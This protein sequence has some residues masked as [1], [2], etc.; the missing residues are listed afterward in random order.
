MATTYRV[1]IRESEA[2]YYVDCTKAIASI[3]KACL[4]ACRYA[5]GELLWAGNHHAKQVRVHASNGDHYSVC[6]VCGMR[7][8]HCDC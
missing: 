5:S 2:A 3:S 7:F 6:P 8:E 1:E 4:V